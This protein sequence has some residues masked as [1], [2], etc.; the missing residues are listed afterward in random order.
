[1]IEVLKDGALQARLDTHNEAFRYVLDHQGQSFHYATN[2]GG[3]RVA[4][5]RNDELDATDQV[6]LADRQWR[7]IMQ[8]CVKPLVGDY[9]RFKGATQE[10]YL[11]RI[12]HHWDFPEVTDPD[13]IM[14]PDE[15]DGK[16]IDSYQTS[17]G[18]SYHLTE[19]GN[20]NYSGGLYPAI[21]AS[22]FTITTELRDARFWFFSHNRWEAH[23][24]VDVWISVPIWEVEREPNH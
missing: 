4:D 5:L 2:Y 19:S 7:R 8:S 3:W 23:N 13:T 1:M 14:Y 11:R 20:G 15:D 21:D 17:D 22:E 6:I 9:V 16:A 24:G 12:S 10:G 18:G